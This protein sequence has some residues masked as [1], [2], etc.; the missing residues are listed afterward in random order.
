[1]SRPSLASAAPWLALYVQAA[2]RECRER[3]GRP[4]PI[5]DLSDCVSFADEAE[6]YGLQALHSARC[7]RAQ[8]ARQEAEDAAHFARR[9]AASIET[10]ACWLGGA[11]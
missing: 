3:T 2:D 10:P 11:A 5:M 4:L 6:R 8:E 7:G 1:V 9:A